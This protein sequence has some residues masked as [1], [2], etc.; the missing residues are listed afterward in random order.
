MQ[1]ITIFNEKGGVGKTTLAGLIGAGLALND[2]RVLLIDADGQGDL[3]KNMN[4]ARQGG[5]FRFVKWGD[6]Q[7]PD[8]VKTKDIIK[9]VP[10]DNCPK[11]LYIVPG[12][13]DSWG[14][15]GSTTLT[16]IVRNIMTRFNDLNKI[17]DFVLIDTQP[18]ATTLHDAIGLVTD[19]FICPTDAEPLSAYGGLV[20]T[21]SHIEYIREQA[22]A[23][24]HDKAK[25][26]GIIPNKYR[27]T[28]S[29]H[30]HVYEKLVELYGDKVWEPLPLR[31]AIPESQYFQ[32]TL[33]HDAPDL[34]TNNYIWSIVDRV[35]I[36]KER[37]NG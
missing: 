27:T 16:Q 24:G 8:Y 4:I 17:F 21:L 1:V 25:L 9:R 26:L 2:N 32:T 20:S 33:L 5:F 3:T 19:Y 12:N 36:L 10:P 11:N 22:L 34:Q 31:T 18:S 37:T 7:H 30:Q 6:P 29:L 28:T 15:P 23:R 14:I 35:K 13:N